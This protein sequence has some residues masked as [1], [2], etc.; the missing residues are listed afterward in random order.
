[1][2]YV[3]NEDAELRSALD[4]SFARKLPR[5]LDVLHELPHSILERSPGVIHLIYDQDVLAN[6]ARHL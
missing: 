2:I 3:K 5:C 1:M 4:S 6:Q